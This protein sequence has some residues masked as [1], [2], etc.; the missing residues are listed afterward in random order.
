MISKLKVIFENGDFLAIDKP[1]GMVVNKSQTTSYEETVQDLVQSK[2]DF[3]KTT[4]NSEF[5]K[6][7]GVVHRLDRETSGV[8]LIAKNE[9]TFDYLQDLFKERDV[10]KEY[11][12]VVVGDVLEDRFEIDAPIGRDPKNRFRFAIVRDAKEASTYFEKLNSTEISDIKFTTL[13]AFPRTGRTHQIRVHLTAYGFPIAGDIVYSTNS[14]RNMYQEMAINRMLLHAVSIKF[15]SRDGEIFNL[16]SEIP[17][18]F[19]KFL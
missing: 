18:D 4:D 5:K 6:R 19:R 16:V 1:S 13:K 10:E 8:L 3:T 17:E 12:A 15:K 14:L 9:E 11:L 7:G 2:L